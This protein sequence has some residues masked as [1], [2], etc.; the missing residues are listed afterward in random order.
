MEC[1]KFWPLLTRNLWK[2]FA[3]LRIKL[4]Q[5]FV[6]DYCNRVFLSEF[7][8]WLDHWSDF[9]IKWL[10]FVFPLC[11]QYACFY[12]LITSGLDFLFWWKVVVWIW[13]LIYVFNM[14]LRKKKI[15][16]FNIFACLYYYYLKDFPVWDGHFI[17][18]KISLH[19]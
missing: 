17:G 19:P 14:I 11:S 5:E 13:Y 9:S 18:S 3:K 15:H 4:Y 16:V 8:T 7:S 10:F 12:Y 1:Y 2:K 6:V